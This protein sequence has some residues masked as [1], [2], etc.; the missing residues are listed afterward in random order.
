MAVTNGLFE[1]L[2]RYS[3]QIL[4]IKRILFGVT[5]AAT[6]HR[7]FW[8]FSASPNMTA[9]CRST[10]RAERHALAESLHR[11]D[12]GSQGRTSTWPVLP[13]GLLHIN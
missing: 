13:R 9:G 3:P 8:A 1:R 10:A 12:R 2:G 11:H 5:M 4:G 6:E 7:R